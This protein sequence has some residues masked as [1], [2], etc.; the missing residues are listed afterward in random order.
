M[1]SESGLR[2]LEGLLFCLASPILVVD[3]A[4]E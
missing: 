1:T 2:A 4:V 3:L